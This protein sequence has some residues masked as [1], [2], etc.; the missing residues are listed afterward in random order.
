MYPNLR[1]ELGR[2]EYLKLVRN[3]LGEHAEN[4]KYTDEYLLTIHPAFIYALYVREIQAGRI[5]GKIPE[6]KNIP[7]AKHYPREKDSLL[8]SEC[9]T[10]YQTYMQES[11]SRLEKIAVV[12]NDGT[13]YTNKELRKRIHDM[14]KGLQ[15]Q[16]IKEN[17]KIAVLTANNIA[18][19]TTV[20][21]ANAIGATSRMV[22]YWDSLE[23]IEGS[24]AE[25]KAQMIVIDEDLL[26]S[27]KVDLSKVNPN[28][29]PVVI[30]N[31]EGKEFIHSNDN[32]ITYDA[33]VEAGKDQKLDIAEHNP[34][35]PALIITS[36]GSTGK[37]KQIA[38]TDAKANYAVQGFWHSEWPLGEKNA[39]LQTVPGHIGSL[40]TIASMYLSLVTGSPLVMAGGIEI[41]ELVENTVRT[42][43]AFPQIRTNANLPDDLGLVVFTAPDF[44]KVLAA[45]YDAITDLS[46]VK[47]IFTTGA[48]LRKEDAEK[49]YKILSKKGLTCYICNGYG[50]NEIAGLFATGTPINNENGT[51]GFPAIGREVLVVEPK[52]Y[53]LAVGESLEGIKIFGPGKEGLILESSPSFCE[54][55]GNPEKTAAVRVYYKDGKFSREKTSGATEYFVTGDLGSID[56]ETYFLS[57]TGRLSRTLVRD[58]CKYPLSSIENKVY[59]ALGA[60]VTDCAMVTRADTGDEESHN[61]AVAFVTLTEKAIQEYGSCEAFNEVINAKLN[62]ADGEENKLGLEEKTKPN[63]IVAIPNDFPRTANKIDYKSLKARAYEIRCE[64]AV[65]KAIEEE[66]AVPAIDKC[67]VVTV[68]READEEK[69]RIAFIT[70]AGEVQAAYGDNDAFQDVIND[71]LKSGKFG[72]GAEAKPE[73]IVV[74]DQMPMTKTG[75]IDH[76]ALEAIASNNL[77]GTSKGPEDTNEILGAQK[78][79]SPKMF[80]LTAPPQLALPAALPPKAAAM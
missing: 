11:E 61:Y 24:I 78:N 80:V 72:I 38:V 43:N 66:F 77:S 23:V 7:W 35:R 18:L 65:K 10:M 73:R 26:T 30:V 32:I 71:S 67:A 46:H 4:P 27:G 29:L 70:V 14:A 68:S 9:M 5:E 59:Q 36:S 39:L 37:P 51:V 16:G 19:P 48:G 57:V 50:Q 45:N 63:L 21:A 3:V 79:D 1:E 12:E 40:G 76:N 17:S 34:E 55:Y 49:L 64:E 60:D 44:I 56:E 47:G 54:Y 42:I 52:L 62:P 13:T 74:I 69:H 53:E 20:L 58:A 22:N 6:G 31:G 8:L 75:V 28:G 41:P 15:A 25:S 2:K 33:L